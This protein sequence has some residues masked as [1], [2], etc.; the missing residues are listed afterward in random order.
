MISELKRLSLGLSVILLCAAILLLS[1]WHSRTSKPAQK[2]TE[3]QIPIAILKVNSN[4]LLDEAEE[5]FISGLAE[6][7]YRDGE[8]ISLK[9]FCPDGDFAV[10]NITFI[11]SR[12]SGM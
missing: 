12:L 4:L 9:R 11:E 3:Q 6:G 7:G 5:G 2:N 1:D 10:Q 8:R